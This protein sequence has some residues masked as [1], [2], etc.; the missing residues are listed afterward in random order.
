MLIKLD[1][2]NNLCIYHT[3]FLGDIALSLFACQ[4]LKNAK[5]HIKI[6]YVTTPLASGIVKCAT[7]I[8]EVII[9]DKRGNSEYAMSIGKLA[10]TLSKKKFDCMIVPHQS[11]RTSRIISKTRKKYAISYKTS[12]LRSSYTHLVDHQIHKHEIYRLFE[13]LNAIDYF[14]LQPK[15]LAIPIVSME[16]ESID[17]EIVEGLLLVN[18]IK[19]Y[20]CVSP[21]SVWETK[22]W[23]GDY[24]VKMIN[25]YKTLTDK[26]IIING[27]K[28]EAVLC[29]EIS[30][31]CGVPSF[32]GKLTVEQTMY[33][34]ARSSG[35]ISNDS[36]P[37]H[38][39]QV[40]NK[41]T[42]AIFGPTI[43]E[44]GFAPII[45]DYVVCED[46][47]L[48]CRPCNIH[49]GHECPKGTLQC[50]LN[51]TPGIIMENAL[52]LF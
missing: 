26:S 50:M 46:K 10:R 49:G 30:E 14:H 5:P 22:R 13:L 42:L 27:S 44:I 48:K 28:S 36:A 16:F 24:F 3:A 7:A 23:P 40:L 37:V 31:K 8:D 9:Y 18:N 29:S 21:G 39:A 47:Q 35:V 51:V 45:G 2:I 34:I 20:V 11:F 17:K 38:F 12:A 43:P 15:P 4:L 33:L 19:E 25:T 41:P 1:K 6:T 32:A 52:K